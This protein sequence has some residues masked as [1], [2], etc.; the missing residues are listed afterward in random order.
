M[1]RPVK[2]WELLRF[3]VG[4]QVRRPWAWAYFG[5]LVSIVLTGGYGCWGATQNR[6]SLRV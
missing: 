4:Y 6:R 5:M 3:E 2:L 1:R